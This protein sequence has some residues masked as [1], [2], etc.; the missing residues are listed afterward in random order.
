MVGAINCAIGSMGGR[1]EPH[2]RE[3]SAERVKTDNAVFSCSVTYAKRLSWLNAT[4]SGSECSAYVRQPGGRQI[5]RPTR[6]EADD[7]TL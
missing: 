6:A 5:I 4:L 2:E 7:P 1:A 3:L